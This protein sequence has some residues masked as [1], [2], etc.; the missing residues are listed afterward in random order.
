LTLLTINSTIG[1]TWFTE[2]L[3]MLLKLFIIINNI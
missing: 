1:Q 3:P 2:Y